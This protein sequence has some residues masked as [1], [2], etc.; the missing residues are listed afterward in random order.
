MKNIINKYEFFILLMP[1]IKD[2]GLNSPIAEFILD[3]PLK[4]WSD[5]DIDA[6]KK[7]LDIKIDSK[8]KSIFNEMA[9]ILIN[10]DYN[11]TISL[12]IGEENM[13]NEVYERDQKLTEY[14]F[15]KNDFL[16]KP[17]LSYK[18]KLLNYIK[19]IDIS[20]YQLDYVQPKHILSYDE[21]LVLN[22]AF[23]LEEMSRIIGLVDGKSFMHFTVQDIIDESNEEEHIAIQGLSLIFRSEDKMNESINISECVNSLLT[24]GYL[25]SLKDE[26]LTIGSIA[27]ILYENLFIP[28]DI[29]F[30]F[31]NKKFI[32]ETDEVY[33]KYGIFRCTKKSSFF[34]CFYNND[35]VIEVISSKA[36]LEKKFMTAFRFDEFK[37]KEYKL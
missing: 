34:F 14:L 19:L 17:P 27:N 22:L 7:E 4:K 13:I 32:K 25:K 12:S 33:M 3:E 21:Y 11:Y 30:S 18:D 2:L 15:N 9:Q 35:I 26:K 23:S 5:I 8:E 1:F 16:I 6:V 36:D 29:Q 37:S 24:K 20:D 31:T 10:P 28:N